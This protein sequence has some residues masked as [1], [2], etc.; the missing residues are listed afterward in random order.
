MAE[1]FPAATGY[2]KV[3][4]VAKFSLHLP[5]VAWH[6]RVALAE[7]VGTVSPVGGGY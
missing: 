7:E 3:V 6:Q 4:K 1:I 5:K 2:M